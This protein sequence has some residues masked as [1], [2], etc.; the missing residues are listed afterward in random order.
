MLSTI[1]RKRSA[2]LTTASKDVIRSYRLSI[3]NRLVVPTSMT[4][5]I[6]E[7]YIHINTRIFINVTSMLN[8]ENVRIPTLQYKLDMRKKYVCMYFHL[9][10]YPVELFFY[11]VNNP[12]YSQHN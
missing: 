2:T 6:C 12:I 9:G 4:I 5:D 1:L 10:R 7:L 11:K 3:I 8:S